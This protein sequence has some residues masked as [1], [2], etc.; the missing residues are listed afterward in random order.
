MQTAQNV[1]R[2]VA[3]VVNL[4]Y[5]R[6]QT[7]KETNE[8]LYQIAIKS[9]KKNFLSSIGSSHLLNTFKVLVHL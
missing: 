1:K 8:S 5:S 6:L 2:Q 7:L 3:S 4:K 9:F